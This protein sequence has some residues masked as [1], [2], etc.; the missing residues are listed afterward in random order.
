MPLNLKK[1]ITA[2]MGGDIDSYRHIIHAFQK[3]V[4]KVV[5]A[6]LHN[7]ETTEEL[8]QET[9]VKA[10]IHL[11]QFDINRDFTKWI[12]GIARNVVREKLRTSFR[13]EKHLSLY[14]EHLKQKLMDDKSYVH[15]NE[16]LA[17]ALDKC[18]QELSQHS[19]EI[20]D[21]RYLYSVSFEKI[22]KKTG[23]SLEATR[24]LLWRIKLKLKECIQNKI[25]DHETG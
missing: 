18:K 22:A 11:D 9:F 20:L 25:A 5:A 14:H 10:Y 15:H 4:W 8:V 7:R 13:T 17:D 23:R 19:K 12:K 16:R 24:Q 2:I 6:M 1:T 21:M 3:E